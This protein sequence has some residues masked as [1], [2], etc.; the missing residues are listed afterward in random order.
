MPEA[1]ERKK[2]ER[3]R[4][5]DRER[6]RG[7]TLVIGVRLVIPVDLDTGADRSVIANV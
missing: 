7:N 3:E 6:V 1:D 5:K 4:D 2:E